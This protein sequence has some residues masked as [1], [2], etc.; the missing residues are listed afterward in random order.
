[1]ASGAVTPQRPP[2]RPGQRLEGRSVQILCDFIFLQFENFAAIFRPV[3]SSMS[4]EL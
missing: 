1:M 4:F 2:R 3:Y